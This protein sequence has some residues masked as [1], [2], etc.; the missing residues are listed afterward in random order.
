MVRLFEL[1]GRYLNKIRRD[2]L[3]CA[4]QIALKTVGCR[5][6]MW[7]GAW[8]QASRLRASD[9]RATFQLE[10]GVVVHLPQLSRFSCLT[11]RG[12]RQ[13]RNSLLFLDR[14][15]SEP[16]LRRFVYECFCAQLLDRKRHI[17]D[18]GAWI[19]DNAVVWA[20]LLS[21]CGLV[22]AVDPSSGN[23]SFGR[24][25]AALNSRKNLE[26]HC[27]VCSDSAG[28]MLSFSGTIDH[29]EF[30]PAGA[31]SAG[32]LRS[33]TLDELVGGGRVSQVGFLHVD[34]EG[35]EHQVLRGASEILKNSQPLIVFEQHLDSDDVAG[36]GRFLE[37][38]GYAVFVMD[39]KLTGC[40]ADCRNLLAIPRG[41][42]SRLDE[43]HRLAQKSGFAL[44][45]EYSRNWNE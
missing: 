29:A 41:A 3:V 27:A 44:I 14:T 13:V 19:S 28:Q 4:T 40:R 10:G 24:L 31:G 18:I 5:W 23:V 1:T 12:E 38:F 37:G 26:Y 16:G 33:T 7:W 45:A 22:I 11:A 39:E 15:E 34:V 43:F 30:T 8:T 6:S 17:I 32:A 25:L 36:L 35:F 42:S 9:Y 21:D 2:G 20:A